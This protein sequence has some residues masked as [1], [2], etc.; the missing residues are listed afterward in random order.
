MNTIF[1]GYQVNKKTLTNDYLILFGNRE[2]GW[3][4]TYDELK[5]FWIKAVKMSASIRVGD[6]SLYYK[7]KLIRGVNN[8]NRRILDKSDN[9]ICKYY[10]HE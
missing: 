6:V 10:K 1:N 5:E 4:C 8:F 7:G 9:F 2:E 3:N